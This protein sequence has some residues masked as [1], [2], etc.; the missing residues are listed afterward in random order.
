MSKGAMDGQS[1]GDDGDELADVKQG[2]MWRRFISRRLEPGGVNQ[3]VDC[4]D[5]VIEIK[6]SDV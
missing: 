6:I 1:G 4:I 3:E 2:E 5:E